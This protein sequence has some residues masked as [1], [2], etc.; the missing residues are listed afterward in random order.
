LPNFV[1][2]YNWGGFGGAPDL[3]PPVLVKGKLTPQPGFGPSGR[4]HHFDT[5]SDLDGTLFW[6][7]QNLGFGNLA[8]LREQQALERQTTLRQ[9]QVQDQVVTQVVQ[10]YELVGGWRDRFETTRSALFDPEGRP[11]GP[12]F[13]ALRLTFDRIRNDV[14][15]R[16]L[17][18]LDSIRSLN[19]LLEAYGQSATD[20]ERA[21]F[22]LLI[23]LGLPAADILEELARSGH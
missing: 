10:S 15:A 8:E 20:Y 1:V 14:N 5:R 7:L 9:L 17:E 22:R 21:R 3:N 11:T 4:I 6:R 16:P 13:Q 18:V 12:V 23:A 2:N 19:D